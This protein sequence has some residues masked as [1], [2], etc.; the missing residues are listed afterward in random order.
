M[1]DGLAYVVSNTQVVSDVGL[2]H[3]SLLTGSTKS[4][5]VHRG[6]VDHRN[7]A[8]GVVEVNINVGN[9]STVLLEQTVVDEHGI[10]PGA[11][12]GEPGVVQNVEGAG[13]NEAAVFLCNLIEP[14]PV[15]VTVAALLR[16]RFSSLVPVPDRASHLVK[17]VA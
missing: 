2:A 13:A 6:A 1:F 16:T 10:G 9:A 7:G 4:V 17:G 11:G 15:Q 12:D 14:L 5:E 8:I 3:R